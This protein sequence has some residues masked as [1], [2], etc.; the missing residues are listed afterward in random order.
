MTDQEINITIVES[1]GWKW[2]RRPATG[3]WAKK[4]MRALYHPELHREFVATLQEAD[5]TERE[6]NWMF[7]QREG[8]IQDY[9]SDLNAIQGAILSLGFDELLTWHVHNRDIAYRDGTSPEL[10]NAS[11]RAEAFLKAINAWKQ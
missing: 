6:C 4:P 8:M 3:P 5:M 7:I 9:C 2:Y 11:Q 1:C 10:T